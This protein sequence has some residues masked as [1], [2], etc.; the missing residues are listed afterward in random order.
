MPVKTNWIKDMDAKGL[1]GKEVLD[2][3]EAQLSKTP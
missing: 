2:Y 1:P 3:A